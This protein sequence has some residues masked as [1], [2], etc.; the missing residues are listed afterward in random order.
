MIIIVASFS[1]S[2]I[3][4]K[5]ASYLKRWTRERAVVASSFL[6]SKRRHSCSLKHTETTITW[7]DL[8]ADRKLEPASVQTS[9]TLTRTLLAS[10]MLIDLNIIAWTRV[11]S[12]HGLELNILNGCSVARDSSHTSCQITSYGQKHHDCRYQ[13][14]RESNHSCRSGRGRYR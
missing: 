11:R 9:S 8:L 4:N 5:R 12:F 3:H 7:Y 2:T 14:C 10:S 6:F 13:S 1:S